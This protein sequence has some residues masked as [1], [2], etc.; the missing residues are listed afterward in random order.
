MLKREVPK[1]GSIRA[2]NA[3]GDNHRGLNI[4]ARE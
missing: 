2:Y 4:V 1:A 3:Y